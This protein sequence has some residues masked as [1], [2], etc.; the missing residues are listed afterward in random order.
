MPNFDKTGPEGKGPLTGRCF[1][2]CHQGN[3][4]VQENC[5]NTD[6]RPRRERCGRGKGCG[7][8]FRHRNGKC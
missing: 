2:K 4:K 7:S 3:E 8:G 6:N 5:E 1:G